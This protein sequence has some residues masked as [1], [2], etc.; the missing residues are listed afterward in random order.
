MCNFEFMKLFIYVYR[1]STEF[2]YEVWHISNTGYKY[3]VTLQRWECDCRKWLLTGLPCCHAISCMRN[4]DMNVYDFMPDIYRKEK[5][6]ACYASVIYP[7]NGQSL[8]ERTEYNDLQ[9]PPIRR[10]PGRPKK[11]RTKEAHEL[12][13]NDTQMKRARWGLKCSRCRE[14][15]HNKSTCKLPPPPAAEVST[16]P[17][18]GECSSQGAQ[19]AQ[20]STTANGAQIA[21]ANQPAQATRPQ[22]TAQTTQRTSQGTSQTRQRSATRQ[23]NAQVATKN[24]RSATR[25]HSAQGTAPTV[26]RTATSQ[27]RAQATTQPPSHVTATTQRNSTTQPPSQTEGS[28]A[29]ETRKRRQKQKLS[30]TQPEGS[31][32][33]KKKAS[34]ELR[35]LFQPSSSYLMFLMNLSHCFLL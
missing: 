32:G 9:P 2:D 16:N 24:Q 35:V 8:W 19:T 20:A 21:Q 29:V 10:Q 11:K 34:A 12:L 7:A 30:T 14:G 31:S 4:Q 1:R 18:S 5:F 6:A 23:H 15:G 26:Q 25:Q 13:K 27:S 22:R 33:K 3:S 28:E 17:A